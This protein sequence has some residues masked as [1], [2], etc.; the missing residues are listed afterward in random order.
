MLRRVGSS[1]DIMMSW[2]TMYIKVDAHTEPSNLKPGPS[3]T[4][5]LPLVIPISFLVL[6]L[7]LACLSI[8]YHAA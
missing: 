2:F 1:L 4:I 5:K 7:F 6:S 8:T 3:R